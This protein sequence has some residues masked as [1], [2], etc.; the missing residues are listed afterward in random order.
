MSELHETHVCRDCGAEITLPY[1]RPDEALEGYW[2]RAY[3]RLVPKLAALLVPVAEPEKPVT[4]GT[5]SMQ[6]DTR[7]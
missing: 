3:W 5:P 6:S 7:A 1:V 4:E 2:E